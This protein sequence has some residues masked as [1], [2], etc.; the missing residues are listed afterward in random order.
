MS[1][2][3]KPVSRPPSW[4]LGDI[5]VVVATKNFGHG[6]ESSLRA[7]LSLDIRELIVVDGF[8]DDGSQSIFETLDR[9]TPGKL[10]VLRAKPA[11]LADAR[12]KGNELA[13]GPLIL[14]AGPDNVLPAETIAE[15]VL[16][17]EH[18]SLVSCRTRLLTTDNYLDRC[19]DLSK[20][21]FAAGRHLPV[22]GTPY[23]AR[24]STFEAFP[25]D[26][27]MVN[28]D[29]TDLCTRLTESGHS[30]SRVSG[31]CFEH[32][33]SNIS[34][35]RERWMRWGRGDALYYRKH[36]GSWTALRKAKSILHPV[37]AEIAEPKKF[38]TTTQYLFSIPFLASVA[39]LRVLGWINFSL[40]AR[41]LSRSK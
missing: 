9:E 5:S 3:E 2:L 27:A 14:H 35:I 16:E 30:I 38:L 39:A 21:R 4:R 24:K 19:H 18:A 33:F 6:L 13:M 8:S 17:L 31:Y 25:F 7:W 34:S 11:G 28:S 32:G 29:D 23:L 20:R 12:Q 26:P 37:I 10:R 41:Q 36:S 1:Q 22:V 40:T 15:M